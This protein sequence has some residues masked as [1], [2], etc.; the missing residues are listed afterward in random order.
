MLRGGKYHYVEP[1][2]DA[3]STTGTS[4]E[5]EYGRVPAQEAVA[6]TEPLLVE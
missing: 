3:P 6:E 1:G 5:G 4:P 2:T